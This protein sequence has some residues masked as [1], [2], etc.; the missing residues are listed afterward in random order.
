MSF[1]NFKEIHF[2]R[3]DETV[4]CLEFYIYSKQLKGEYGGV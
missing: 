4:D 2:V 3:G 1:K